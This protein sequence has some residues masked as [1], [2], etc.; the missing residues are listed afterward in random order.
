M[1]EA[2]RVKNAFATRDGHQQSATIGATQSTTG[3]AVIVYAGDCF[4]FPVVQSEV[5]RFRTH[6]L[7]SFIIL[8][9]DVVVTM[10]ATIRSARKFRASFHPR[11]TFS[12]RRLLPLRPQS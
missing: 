5:D 9:V 12:A 8:A 2:V 7:H 4:L 6:S 1:R 3:V 10:S 11:L